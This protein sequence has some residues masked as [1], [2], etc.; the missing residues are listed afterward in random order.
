ME[1]NKTEFNTFQKKTNTEFLFQMS[2]GSL[3]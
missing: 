1:K 3:D 2:Q